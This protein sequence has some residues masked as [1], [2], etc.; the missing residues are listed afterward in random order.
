MS[1]KG[2]QRQ[3]SSTPATA[4]AEPLTGGGAEATG[5]RRWLFRV[6]LV[7]VPFLVLFTLELLLRVAGYGVA[8]DFVLRQDVEGEPR[9]LSNPRFT[10]LFFEPGVARIPPPFSLPLTKPSGTYRVFV[11]GDSAA[12][13]DPEPA[14]GIARMLEV[15]LRD[16]YPGVEFEVVN[17]AATAVN[18]HF[19]YASARACLR[20]EPDL[21]VL[22]TGNNEVV[23]PYGAGT[24][25]TSAAPQL[26]LV[27]AALSVRGTRL[28]QLVAGSLR[29]AGR[30]LGRPQ[31]PAAWHGMEMFLERQLRRSDAALERTYR[32]FERNLEDTCRAAY[33]A[34]VPLVL[35]TIAVNLRNC[36]PFASLHKSALSAAEL[37]DWEALFRAGAALEAEGRCAEAV[38]PLQEAAQ[39]DPEHAETLYRLGR[40]EAQLGHDADARLHLALARDLDT[41]RFRADT[42]TNATVRDVARRVSGL[43]LV[44]ADQLLAAHAPHGAAG[45]ETFVDHVHLTFHG[46]YLLTG[47]LLEQVR[48]AL[49]DWVRRH[50]S[51]EALPSEDE[52]GRRL[53]YTELDRYRIAE[54]MQQRLRDAPF[55]AQPDHAEHVKRFAD[56]LAWLRARGDTGA[57]EASL[58]QYEQA[59]AGEHP[60][61]TLR[62]RYAAIL[63]RSGKAAEATAEWTTLTRQFPQYP[64][65]QLQ[66]ARAL[67]DT[68]H[69]PEARAALQ[70]VLDYQPEAPVT[71]IEVARLELMQGHTAEAIQAA[72]HAVALD[73]RDATALNTLAA[74]LC[75][76][77]ECAPPARAEAITLLTRALELAPESAAV[78][79]ELEELQKAAG[80]GVR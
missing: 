12:Q 24:V 26:P 78:R 3:R 20:L 76:R 1:R 52:V 15:L 45:D 80:A 7:L 72:R 44:D 29:A 25:L 43:R 13:G 61:W 60:H 74:S 77:Y 58:K 23:G 65:F 54:T 4:V 47:A 6:I 42:R 27:R 71:L 34:G 39:L 36:G 70:K 16:Q 32:T 8:M 46:N 31:P 79:H 51:P 35:S 38:A 62:E 68:Q 49:P 40:C 56:E 17:A 64:A 5:R 22:Y 57:V 63:K 48:Q 67:R 75:P 18:S 19:V 55:S 69:L 37:A 30:G 73:P 11:L 59:L 14:F 33:R 28:G 10:W 9:Y 53:V 21:L 50:G 41:L 66:L 2:K